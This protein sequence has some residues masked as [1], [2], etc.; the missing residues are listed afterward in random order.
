MATLTAGYSLSARMLWL[1]IGIVLT[2]EALAFAPGLARE[3]QR[4]LAERFAQADM[5][6]LLASAAPGGETDARTR[7]AL[8]RR[9]R[10][11]EIRLVDRGTQVILV[12]PSM[13]AERQ[14]GVEDRKSVV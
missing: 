14:P 12:A 8:L 4:W 3:R 5:A 7:D 9:A 13:P 11:N 2:T 1:A 10:I 6:I